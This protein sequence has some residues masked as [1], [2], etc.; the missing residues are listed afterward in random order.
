MNA[1]SLSDQSILKASSIYFLHSK[2]SGDI[3]SEAKR[4]NLIS[5]STF[6]SIHLLEK[7]ERKNFTSKS[8]VEPDHDSRHEMKLDGVSSLKLHYGQSV[9]FMERFLLT[10][11]HYKDITE[12]GALKNTDHRSG[13]SRDH[14]CELC[15]SQEKTFVVRHM[16]DADWLYLAELSKNQAPEDGHHGAGDSV[17]KL[18]HSSTGIM[19]SSNYVQISAQK[20]LQALK[21]IPASARRSLPVIVNS[22]DLLLSIPSICFSRCPLLSVAVVFRPRVPLG[23]GYS[24]YI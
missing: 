3:L 2:S 16:V 6:T 23:G 5:E 19:Q 12:H 9:H 7:E 8:A 1:K 17:H 15:M 20:A 24:S 22:Q 10:W 13:G 18:E 4:M 11:K 21:S 14:L